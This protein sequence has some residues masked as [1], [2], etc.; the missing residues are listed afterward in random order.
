MFR[1]ISKKI[2]GYVLINDCKATVKIDNAS[3]YQ[4]NINIDITTFE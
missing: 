4:K 1:K 3:I 2:L